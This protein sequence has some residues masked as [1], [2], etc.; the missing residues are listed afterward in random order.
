MEENQS[1]LGMEVEPQGRANLTEVA[2]WGK[3]LAI[4]GY[5]FM[6]LFIL[7]LA[8]AWSSFMSAFTG[9]YPDP[10]ERSIVSTSSGFFLVVIVLFIGIFFTLLFFLL[11]GA[12]RIKAGLRD[13][14]QA[15][16]NSGLA[17][18]RNYFIMF[19]VLSILRI[20]FAL[21]SLF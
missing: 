20:L 10:Y 2:R 7:M 14:D 21:M 3:F 13:N 11:K 4:V 8:F 1:I 16:F 12:N 9:S 17:N 5:V 6:G 18:L 19:G 15:V